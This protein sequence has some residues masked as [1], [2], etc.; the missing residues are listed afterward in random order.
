MRYSAAVTHRRC[1]VTG[2]QGKPR[3]KPPF[4]ANVGVFGC[5]TTVTVPHS[6][7]LA[8]LPLIPTSHVTCTTLA[9]DGVVGVEHTYE[10]AC[11]QLL[12]VGH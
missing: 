10:S 7:R 6:P 12:L 1:I 8:F 2:K 4:P 3:L 11:P 9:R 5:P